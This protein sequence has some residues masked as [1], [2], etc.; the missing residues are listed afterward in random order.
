MQLELIPVSV[1]DVI[2]MTTLHKIAPFGS[3]GR[4]P[5]CPKVSEA[6]GV[7]IRVATGGL[8]K[9]VTNQGTE[10]PRS[11]S[12]FSTVDARPVT[13]VID[14]TCVST[15]AAPKPATCAVN[16]KNLQVPPRFLNVDFWAKY[17]PDVFPP[18]E[19]ESV[20][21]D[22][23][24]GVNIGRPPAE[25]ILE[26]PNWPSAV[27]FSDK[28]DDVVRNDMSLN[29]LHGP[30]ITPPYEHYVISP[31]GAFL[32]RDGVKVRVIHDLSYPHGRA[33]NSSIDPEAYSLYYA[34]IDIAVD[35]CRNR[36]RPFLCNID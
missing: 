30:F 3:W 21:Y 22:I 32:K 26:S 27:H 13:N 12:S 33:V 7:E 35:A 25:C 1:Q 6:T 8:I 28:V 15:V 36:D 14:S 16:V 11:A 20:L 31:L 2:R 17:L 19:A 18:L 29:R 23:V 4:L 24:S 34:S 5:I 9:K 10:H